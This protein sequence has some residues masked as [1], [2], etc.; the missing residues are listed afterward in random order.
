MKRKRSSTNTLPRPETFR[1]LLGELRPSLDAATKGSIRKVGVYG[2]ALRAAL[3]KSYEFASLVHAEDPPAH[4]FFITATLRGISEDLIV[5]TYL[6][7]LGVDERNEVA[8]LL[9]V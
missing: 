1:S 5:L 9:M 2:C 6:G 8:S 4:G 7:S 3:A